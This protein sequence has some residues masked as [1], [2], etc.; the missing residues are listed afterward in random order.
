MAYVF[1]SHAHQ[2]KPFARKL[3]GDLRREG[4]PVWL[5]EAEI[6][7]GD[8]LV[9]KI[10]EGLKE[11][12]YVVAVLSKHSIESPWVAKEL[13]FASN[14]EINERRVVVLPL[15]VDDVEI[16]VFLAG[17]LYGDFRLEEAYEDGFELVLRALGP[18]DKPPQPEP[19]EIELLKRE[20]ELVRKM[21]KREA[22]AAERA[23]DAAYQAKSPKLKEAIE[24]ANE[25]FPSHAPINKTFAFEIEDEMITLDYALWSIMKS[26]SGRG[27]PLQVLLTID[28]RWTDLENM[29]GAY[30]DMIDRDG[31]RAAE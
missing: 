8:S 12:D 5:D 18:V 27:H 6:N 2:D 21:A 16:P 9:E 17:K 11:V 20:L 19:D 28:E 22:A 4:H 24:K 26:S 14:R 31:T 10:G 30:L 25:K 15:L 1:L 13:E 23:G 7:I 3:A 29:M